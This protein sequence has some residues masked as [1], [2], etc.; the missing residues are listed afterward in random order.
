[1][2]KVLIER[3]LLEGLEQEYNEASRALLQGCMEFSGYISG[4]SLRNLE[5]PNHRIIITHWKSESAWRQWETSERR[6]QLLGGVA[7]ILAADEKVTLLAP[8]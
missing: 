4:E 3:H 5:S 2:I 7:G 1:M 8:V 6:L